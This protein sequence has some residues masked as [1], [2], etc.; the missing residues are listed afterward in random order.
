MATISKDLAK[1]LIAELKKQKRPR[2]YCIAKYWNAVFKKH[3]YAMLE[4][5]DHY[6]ALL[7]SM[8]SDPVTLLWTSPRFKKTHGESA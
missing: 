4:N 5:E 1:E 7:A 3:G 8:G 2:V 6:R